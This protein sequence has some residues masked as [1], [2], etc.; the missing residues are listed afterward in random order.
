MYGACIYRVVA[1]HY[2]C[3]VHQYLLSVL[4]VIQWL[5]IRRVYHAVHSDFDGEMF[6]YRRRVHEKSSRFSNDLNRIET[7]KEI[8]MKRK[9]RYICILKVILSHIER[10]IEYLCVILDNLM[11]NSENVIHDFH[12]LISNTLS[13]DL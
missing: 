4:A 2:A 6:D 5:T 1:R 12:F 9:Y 11:I 3:D 13:L 8:L 7:C 10:C